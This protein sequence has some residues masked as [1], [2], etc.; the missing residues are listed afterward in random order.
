MQSQLRIVKNLDFQ[1]Y[2][3]KEIFVLEGQVDN[4]LLRNKKDCE[5]F[6]MLNLSLFG[7][8]KMLP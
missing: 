2:D 3:F 7:K 8:E 5:N 4:F 6:N 1:R